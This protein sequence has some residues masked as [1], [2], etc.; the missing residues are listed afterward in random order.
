MCY[1]HIIEIQTRQYTLIINN[2]HKMSKLSEILAQK[3][4]I[5][6]LKID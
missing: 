5:Y 2:I 3:L 6:F 1:Y 4:Y